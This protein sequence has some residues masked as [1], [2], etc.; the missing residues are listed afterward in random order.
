[1]GAGKLD[2]SEAASLTG[3]TPM[4]TVI[5]PH[6]NDLIRLD[7]CLNALMQQSISLT[8]FE[9]VVADNC[10]PQGPEEVSRVI[11]ARARMIT[12]V[13]R[14]AGAARNGAVSVARG[15]TLAFTDSDCVPDEK[16]LENGLAAL[17]KWHIVGGRVRVNTDGRTSISP[18]EAFE[19][20]FAFNFDKYINKDG[21]TGSG[22]M[23]VA[24]EIFLS[25]G[26]F[27]ASVS[28]DVEWCH[29]ATRAGLT[30]GYAPKAVVT[31]PARK[32]WG[33]LRQKW[34]RTSAESFALHCQTGALGKT[35]WLLRTWALPGSIFIHSFKVFSSTEVSGM[36][37]RLGALSTLCRI[38]LWRFVE[39]HRLLL[40]SLG[41][42]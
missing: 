13:E 36:P 41:L 15:T 32:T 38:R 24:K 22:N 19:K 14:G 20:V 31:H 2:Q 39:G 6:Y 30:L 23:F 5:V 25:V 42:A 9:I 26:G 35:K 29:R 11:G 1:L 7:R 28:E 27:A 37:Q 17:L 18:T 10:S 40:N 21:F 8:D 3:D 34:T 33:E 16:W 12:V 4:I